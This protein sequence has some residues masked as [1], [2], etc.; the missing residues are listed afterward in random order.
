MPMRGSAGKRTGQ[1]RRAK[2]TSRGSFDKP[3]TPRTIQ[4]G[5]TWHTP[6]DERSTRQLAAEEKTPAFDKRT[7]LARNALPAVDKLIVIN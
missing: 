5:G 2:T 7:A 4:N 3:R 1:R 6:Q